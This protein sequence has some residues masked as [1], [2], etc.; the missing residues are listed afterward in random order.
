MTLGQK[1]CRSPSRMKDRRGR[2]A[3]P[4]R[5][6]GKFQPEKTLQLQK[7]IP[8]ILGQSRLRLTEPYKGHLHKQKGE[9]T[10]ESP[11][12]YR[13]GG[14]PLP[15][16]GKGNCAKT[17]PCPPKKKKTNPTQGGKKPPD[18]KGL[19]LLGEPPAAGGVAKK[20]F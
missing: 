15:N 12:E 3:K 4:G 5:T 16:Y 11:K 14:I 17:T 9:E 7:K 6:G 2:S 20:K 10:P 8:A 19:F 18:Q 13:I 1:A